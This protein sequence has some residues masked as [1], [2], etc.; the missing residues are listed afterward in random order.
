MLGTRRGTANPNFRNGK[1]VGAHD[2]DRRRFR[3]YQTECQHPA[4]PGTERRTNEHH[5]VYEQKVRRVGGDPYDGR[6][7]LLVCISCHM[8]HHRRGRRVIPLVALRDE[9]YEFAVELLGAAAFDYLRR[10]Y[11]GEDPRLQA[12]LDRFYR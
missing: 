2:R 8:S 9:N 12:V 5:V 10:R 4:C 3:S 1:R 11:V 7:A 6:N